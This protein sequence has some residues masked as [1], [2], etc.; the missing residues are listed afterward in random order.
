[1]SRQAALVL[2][3]AAVSVG[4]CRC[5]PLLPDPPKQCTPDGAGCLSDE[6]CVDFQCVP[7]PKCATDA[8]CDS[9]AF[10]CVLPA[11]VCQLREGFGLECSAAAPCVPGKFCALGICR[12]FNEDNVCSFD[13]DCRP[14]QRCDRIDVQCIP[15][16]DCRLT[17]AFPELACFEQGGEQCDALTGRCA[18]PC[19]D[20]PVCTSDGDCPSAGEHCNGSC[21]CVQCISNDDCGPG[22]H[23]D[24]RSGDCHSDNECF[25]DSDCEPPLVCGASAQCEV[26]P[27]PCFSDFDCNFGQTCDVGTNQ[28]QFIG[29]G[30]CADDCFDPAFGAGNNTPATAKALT[31]NFGENPVVD[32]LVLCLNNDDVYSVALT[33]GDLLIAH[34]DGTDPLAGA[35]MTL[36][37]A[38]GE[39]TLDFAETPPRGDGTIAFVAQSDETVYLRL[40]ALQSTR[41][42][43]GGTPYTLQ[44]TRENG[45]V[46]QPDAFES[47]PNDTLV[48]ATPP[49][50]VPDGV[51]LLGTVCPGDV[52]LYRVDVASGEGL[53]A[54]LAFDG[55]A[56][57]LDLAFLDE[58]G[59]LVVQ[60]GGVSQPETLRHRFPFAGS[61]YVRVRGFGSDIGSYNLTV[62]HEPP[63]VCVPDAAEPADNDPSTAP[64]LPL[65]QALGPEDHTMCSGDVDTV[66]TPLED[67]ER[68][69]VSALYDDAD[70]ELAIDIVDA[71]DGTT[72]LATSPPATGGAA[73]S[74]DARANETVFVR[75]GGVG[76]AVGPYQLHI[77]KENQLD[78]APDALEPNNTVAQAK[79]LPAPGEL[80][81]M[82][83][84]DAD[85]FS[86]DGNAG[87]K[88][89]VDASFR[90]AEGDID[91]QL[92]GLDGSQI[93]ATADGTSDGEHLEVTL[94]LDGTYTLR[95][96]SLSGDTRSR[97]TLTVS[98]VSP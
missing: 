55:A 49:E 92:I 64:T 89:V 24:T 67:F 14:G 16:G 84:T 33:A 94:P 71:A 48:S 45:A 73:V 29:G 28:C 75:V 63:F 93:L 57:D 58:Q 88:L 18:Q 72:V 39:N 60:D 12:D 54:N 46:C 74:Y 44:L 95:V 21:L 19:G 5:G 38:T 34:V 3:L 13:T 2:A 78:C 68:M 87:K 51:V 40:S 77:E 79:P 61:V 80:L 69:I 66:V 20:P 15:D 59:T 83:G 23:C 43:G 17:D 27:P 62:N 53:S 76:G 25:S 26:A 11:Q 31:V 36:L 81:S 10:Q 97:Y 91:L 37:D 30:A 9:P 47:P 22:L 6:I 86:I 1:M 82:C 7:R 70:V 96:F 90:Q 85:F 98:E 8:D 41:Q 35:T 52:D 4:S 50:Q 32:D 65:N 56:T 42:D